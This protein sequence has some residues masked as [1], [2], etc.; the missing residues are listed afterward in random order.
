MPAR[1][2]RPGRLAMQTLF[3]FILLLHVWEDVV[4]RSDENRMYTCPGYEE[5]TPVRAV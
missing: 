3:I 4:S 1:P 5:S 2:L